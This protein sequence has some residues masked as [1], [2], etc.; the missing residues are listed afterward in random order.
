VKIQCA[1]GKR[2]GAVGDAAVGDGGT[3]GRS[4]TD[5]QSSRPRR[6]VEVCRPTIDVGNP[7]SAGVAVAGEVGHTAVRVDDGGNE[8][9][10]VVAE[11]GHPGS[12]PVPSIGDGGVAGVAR[13][14]ENR[15]PTGL[16]D[17][18]GVRG[19]AGGKGVA[20]LVEKRCSRIGV[21]NGGSAGGAIA[22]EDGRPEGVVDDG[23]VADGAVVAE[24]NP[25]FWFTILAEPA[26]L[27]SKNVVPPPKKGLLLFWIE[28]KPAV[29]VCRNEVRPVSV[30]MMLAP[31]PPLLRSPLSEAVA[32][33]KKA[34]L[35][36]N[37]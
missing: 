1:A 6:V 7:G 16:V 4:V 20:L 14:S 12:A 21:D 18:R 11:L 27:E 34:K 32:L 23:G 29:L 13:V 25:R 3:R 2:L 5:Q 9:A 15:E 17:D 33:P 35:P 19:P 31:C 26:V 36:S 10:A 22:L 24:I 37:D 30:L 8:S 28:A